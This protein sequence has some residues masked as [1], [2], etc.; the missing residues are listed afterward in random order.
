MG[1]EDILINKVQRHFVVSYQ[2]GDDGEFVFLCCRKGFE[3]FL[4]RRVRTGEVI[5]TIVN[6][7]EEAMHDINLKKIRNQNK[8]TFDLDCELDDGFVI[9]SKITLRGKGSNPF[10]AAVID[11][12]EAIADGKWAG[13]E[14]RKTVATDQEVADM[15]GEM[16]DA[17]KEHNDWIK[18]QIANR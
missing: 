9:E 18:E 2:Y 11:K 13:G 5:P 16:L 10:H 1:K 15:I 12:L 8:I 14:V 6:L 17:E 7:K 4:G 3:K